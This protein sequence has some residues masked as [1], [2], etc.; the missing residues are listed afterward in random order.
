MEHTQRP[1]QMTEAELRR[2]LVSHH[3]MTQFEISSVLDKILNSSVPDGLETVMI[4]HRMKLDDELTRAGE[5]LLM[6][7]ARHRD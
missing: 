6:L 4:E 7:A 3:G 5:L 2:E 1:G